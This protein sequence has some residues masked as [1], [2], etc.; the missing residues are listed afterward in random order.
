[1][2]FQFCYFLFFALSL[3]ALPV[4]GDDQAGGFRDVS[5]LKANVDKYVDKGATYLSDRLQPT[6]ELA[7]AGG[8]LYAY[9][10]IYN[11]VGAVTA[12]A[13]R[14][15]YA[16]G[17][18]LYMTQWAKGDRDRTVIQALSPSTE[19][20][21][22]LKNMPY[23][24][25][26]TPTLTYVCRQRGQAWTRPFVNVFEPGSQSLPGTIKSVTYPEVTAPQ[27]IHAVA[28]RVMHKDGSTQLIL[29]CDAEA[30]TTV[31]CEGKTYQVNRISI[32]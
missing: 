31:Q 19:G 30:E 12:S 5:K 1:M 13:T 25:R 11:K 22:R 7:F 15:Q 16:V 4:R 8:H 28:V 2:K 23:D 17:D 3:A 20:L 10:Y 29:S 14:C 26:H 6:D 24:I 21:S 9:S 27:G 32:Q 18:T